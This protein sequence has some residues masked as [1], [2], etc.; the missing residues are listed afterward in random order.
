MK[1]EPKVYSGLEQLPKGKASLDITKGC[2]VLEGGAFRGV[3]TSGVCDCLMEHNINFECT[4]G[5][6]AGALNGVGYV[7]GDIGRSARI[8]LGYR[9]D[10]RYVGYQAF[11]NNRGVIGFNFLFGGLNY[12]LPMDVKRLV[13]DNRR[14]IAVATACLTGETK[15][16]ESH[17][18]D[19]IFQAV[20]ASATMPYVS[21]MVYVDG[22]PYLDGGCSCK[23]PFEWALKEGYKKV[24]VVRT[25]DYN[26][27]EKPSARASKLAELTYRNYPAFALSLSKSKEETNREIDLLKKLDKEGKTF[28]IYPSKP[29]TIGRLEP[30]MEKLGNLYWQ[31]YHDMEERLPLLLE[32]LKTE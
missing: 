29:I 28:T 7:A 11:K 25:R 17:D 23:M 9:H 5:V 14:F 18:V 12:D 10:G 21:E 6:S 22:R 20:Q 30:D 24:V 8:N 2:L 32:Y 31:G 1:K 26:Y 3:Y 13:A 16:F 4:A 15:Y 19:K 27:Y